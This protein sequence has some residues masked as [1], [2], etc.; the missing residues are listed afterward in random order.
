[1]RAVTRIPAVIRN[2]GDCNITEAIESPSRN[3]VERLENKVKL[4]QKQSSERERKTDLHS[5]SKSLSLPP[6]Y[7]SA[8]IS[9]GMIA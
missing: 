7:F 9:H 2:R 8:S 4:S 1:M 3:V 5:G 6:P